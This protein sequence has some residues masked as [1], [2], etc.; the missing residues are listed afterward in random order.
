[1]SYELYFKA[2]IY[3]VD[4]LKTNIYTSLYILHNNI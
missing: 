2:I 4:V 3:M 1:M